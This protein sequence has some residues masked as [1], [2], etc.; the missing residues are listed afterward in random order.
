MQ[1]IIENVIRSKS[2]RPVNKIT[3]IASRLEVEFCDGVQ[4]QQNVS[5][6][7]LLEISLWLGH[8]LKLVL[9]PK[10]TGC[11]YINNNI[12]KVC[13]TTSA[14]Q[15]QDLALLGAR[16]GDHVVINDELLIILV[17]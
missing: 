2:L 10:Q 4:V 1:A 16:A 5:P 11:F 12:N 7:L 3:L 8:N 6:S 13:T 9:T 15:W 17:T 14:D